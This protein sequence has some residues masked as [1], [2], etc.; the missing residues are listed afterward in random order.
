MNWAVRISYLD[1]SYVE[2][3]PS[4]FNSYIY[5]NPYNPVL[6]LS[7]NT[8]IY[9]EDNYRYYVDIFNS[10]GSKIKTLYNSYPQIDKLHKIVWDGTDYKG[11]QVA[12]GTYILRH[13]SNKINKSYFF[14]VIK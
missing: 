5:P 9:T 12:S 8:Y 3:I 6:D 4:E 14:T 7:L 1:T 11:N 13:I 2:T 10:N